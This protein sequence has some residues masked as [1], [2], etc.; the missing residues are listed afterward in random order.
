MLPLT[1]M[2]AQEPTPEPDRISDKTTFLFVQ[3]FR[4][5]TLTPKSPAEP[6]AGTPVAGSDAQFQLHL[7]D[8]MGQ[9]IYFSDRPERIVGAVPTPAFLDG[10]GFSPADPPNAALVGETADGLQ[11]VIVV[12]LFDPRY[13]FATH[14][15]TYD[16]VQNLDDVERLGF[17]LAEPAGLGA[18]E[19]GTVY[20]T[21]NLF[22][23]DCADKV[24]GCFPSENPG[25]VTDQFLTV[26][27]CWSWG[28]LCC[29]W[30]NCANED[31]PSG[32]CTD[33]HR[34]FCGP[35]GCIACDGAWADPNNPATC[36]N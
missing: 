6:E 12:E 34:D 36:A 27:Q 14:S 21:A 7:A 19:T 20:E 35:G 11:E 31:P 3:A 26:G 18:H 8:G 24:Y 33:Q 28:C 32:V 17:A 9:T 2:A 30:T 23:D 16:I 22:I 1:S 15:V 10:L 29:H 5:G 4:S 13:D 25:P